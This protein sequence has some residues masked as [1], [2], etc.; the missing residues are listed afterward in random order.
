MGRRPS[1]GPTVAVDIDGDLLMY[2]DNR[3]TGKKHLT[4]AAWVA[5]I[6]Q[7]E[8]LLTARGP[9]VV[10]NLDNPEDFIAIAAALISVSPGRARVVEA[11]Q[12]VLNMLRL[13]EVYVE[14]EE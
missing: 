4:D 1:H 9:R 11:P 3:L 12:E 13:T 7:R 2:C 10:A 5:S 8:V 6:M 14:E